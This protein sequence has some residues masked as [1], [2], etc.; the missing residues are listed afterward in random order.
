MRT[1][2][3][4]C[5]NHGVFIIT[6]ILRIHVAPKALC[7]HDFIHWF[8]LWGQTNGRWIHSWH[9]TVWAVCGPSIVARMIHGQRT[10]QIPQTETACVR[11]EL[12]EREDDKCVLFLKL[13]PGWFF[14]IFCEGSVKEGGYSQPPPRRTSAS[15]G[16]MDGPYRPVLDDRQ[17][18]ADAADTAR[19]PLHPHVLWSA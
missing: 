19:R 2:S 18:G 12:E 11:P 14:P 1:C 6:W 16:Q 8:R 13:Q 3:V 15:H 10:P 7:A 9:H 5:V 17:S 4:T